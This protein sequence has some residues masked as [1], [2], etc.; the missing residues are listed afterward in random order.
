M[1]ASLAARSIASG[2]VVAR[3]YEILDTLGSGGM[4]TVFR[5]LDRALDVRVA[6]KVLKDSPARN[7][8]L[9]RRFRSEIKLA[10]RVRHR[11][12]CGIHEYGEDGDV[13]YI[14]MEL[15]EGKDL[16]R[17][18]REHGPLEWAQAYDVAIQIGEGLEAIHE[19]GVIHRDLKPANVTRDAR[20]LVRVM[21]FGIAKVWGEDSGAGATG[22]GHVVG[23][24]EYMSPEQV[25]GT[26]LDF[27]SDL[28]ALGL[29]VYELFTG[30]VP[31][32]GET[33]GAVMMQRLEKEP[34]WDGPA[35]QM[36]PAAAVPILRKAL[37]REPA[38]R[39]ASCGE[40]LTD[41]RAARAVLWLHTTDEIGFKNGRERSVGSM[42][43]SV[44]PPVP[45]FSREAQARLLL[46][47]LLK[48]LK[49]ADKE[50]RLGAVQA[51]GRLAGDA[52]LGAPAS[53]LAAEALGAAQ[54]EDDDERVRAGATRALAQLKPFVPDASPAA[55]PVLALPALQ[56]SPEPTRTDERRAPPAPAHKRASRPATRVARVAIAILGVAVIAVIGVIRI[57]TP[58]PRVAAP[59]S[60]RETPPVTT[61]LTV[62]E[63]TAAP[64]SGPEPAATEPPATLAPPVV[65]PSTTPAIVA[66]PSVPK[67]V[68]TT[69]A[70]EPSPLPTPELSVETPSPLPSP[71]PTQTPEIVLPTPPVT[72]SAPTQA[73][74][75]VVP[76]ACISCPIPE[77]ARVLRERLDLPR[78]VRL[79]IHV[80]DTGEALRV[81]YVAG[82]APVRDAITKAA[83]RWRYRPARRGER[84]VASFLD[85]DLEL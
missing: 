3:R 73:P 32:P 25:R 79:R 45:I 9:A 65:P 11:N 2:Y 21:D 6:L 5:A 38:G 69:P 59:E 41:L 72:E 29:V 74:L 15:V 57:R 30:S 48:A 56:L 62:P 16:K 63:A 46:P 19:A 42:D 84:P 83:L 85:L 50:V 80:S 14:S 39:Y 31:F 33:P 20:G 55:P 43:G 61:L 22:T 13:L 82:P 67:P 7:P 54:R 34:D 1:A 68:V 64:P 10:W 12:V 47:P 4:A 78:A 70:K 37:A 24:P 77:A 18:L 52:L 49:H 44:Q 35:A 53:R 28:Y 26:S 8:E 81:D 36:I 76:A 66:K 23:S 51:L 60:S 75:V 17:L 58:E 71:E 27:R 40:L